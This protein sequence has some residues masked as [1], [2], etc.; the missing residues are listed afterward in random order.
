[1]FEVSFFAFFFFTAIS[2]D[3]IHIIVFSEAKSM[4]FFEK[5]AVHFEGICVT[6]CT[7]TAGKN[8][9]AANGQWNT[10]LLIPDGCNMKS[11]SY[12]KTLKGNLQKPKK[13]NQFSKTW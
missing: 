9:E 8:E 3:A 6:H 10:N 7:L 13:S 2:L 1:M 11:N 4:L 12:S 5:V